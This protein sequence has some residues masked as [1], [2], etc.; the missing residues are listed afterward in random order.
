MKDEITLDKE[1]AQESQEYQVGRV[2]KVMTIIKLDQK[3]KK[4]AV[5]SK[6]VDKED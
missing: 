3:V 1:D 2:T 5:A 4:S 6:A